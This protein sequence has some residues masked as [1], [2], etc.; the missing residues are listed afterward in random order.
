M[1][2]DKFAA[3]AERNK[4]TLYNKYFKYGKRKIYS[5]IKKATKRGCSYIIYCELHYKLF[6][7]LNIDSETLFKI[8]QALKDDLIKHG[9]YVRKYQFG[10]IKDA[11]D[12]TIAWGNEIDKHKKIDE[13]QEKIMLDRRNKK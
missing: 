8:D 5:A 11:F 6:L 3:N 7:H 9:F 13:I 1:L 2:A 4:K 10:T 12:Y